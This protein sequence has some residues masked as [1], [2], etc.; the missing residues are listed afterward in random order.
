MRF[1][2]PGIISIHALR[3]AL[4]CTLTLGA[5]ACSSDSKDSDDA[6]AVQATV[7]VS[8]SKSGGDNGTVAL[9]SVDKCTRDANSGRADIV[10]SLGANAPSLTLAIKD[11]SSDPK[12]Y[13]CKQGSDN[14]TS[15]TDVGIKFETCMAE[16]KVKASAT[17]TTLNGYSM[18][19]ETVGVKPF[20][21]AGTCTIAVTAATPTITGKVT[22]TD[23]VQTTLEGAV[24]NPIDTAVTADLAA[25]FS[26][27]FR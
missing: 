5:S 24:R 6:P 13:E 26:C 25:D 18:Y 12:T 8:D 17:A 3:T 23:L 2:S 11:Y 14:K 21:Y 16:V 9:T 20:S 1:P 7:I 10:L 22:C 19:R 27:T 15:A 4:A